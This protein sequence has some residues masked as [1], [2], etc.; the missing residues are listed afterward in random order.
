MSG[1]APQRNG[2]GRTGHRTGETRTV[3]DITVTS[4]IIPADSGYCVIVTLAG[5]P[6]LTQEAAKAAEAEIKNS[7]PTYLLLAENIQ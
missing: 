3:R 4:D 6:Y 5:G 2:P 1:N 7:V